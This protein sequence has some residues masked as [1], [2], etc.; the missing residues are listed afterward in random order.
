M[1][2]PEP[3]IE[4]LKA[5][6]S[7]LTHQRNSLSSFNLDWEARYALLQRDHEAL[8]TNFATAIANANKPDVSAQ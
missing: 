8:K 7:I 6:V 2:Q 1:N 3:T 4:E 5:Q